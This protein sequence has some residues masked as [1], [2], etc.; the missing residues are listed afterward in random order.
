MAQV[1]IGQHSIIYSP[2]ASGSSHDGTFTVTVTLQ[3]VPYRAPEN[4]NR[5][6]SLTLSFESVYNHGT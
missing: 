1:V 2:P 3:E 5:R 6:L 4:T